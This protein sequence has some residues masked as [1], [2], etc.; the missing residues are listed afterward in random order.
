M[1]ILSAA[2]PSLRAAE[3]VGGGWQGVQEL[4]QWLL[5][6]VEGHLPPR[7]VLAI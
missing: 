2:T 6:L 4:F 7:M 1:P 3:R 5:K